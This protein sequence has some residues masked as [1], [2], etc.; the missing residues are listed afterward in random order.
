MYCVPTGTQIT[1]LNKT[2]RLAGYRAPK[3]F[4]TLK[5]TQ[6]FDV[7]SF[8]LL[9]LWW[10][11]WRGCSAPGVMGADG[12]AGGVD[13]GGVRRGADEARASRGGGGDDGGSPCLRGEGA[14]AVAVDGGGRED[15]GRCPRGH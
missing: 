5:A 7:Y 11:Q 14:G 10:R 6:T 1:I 4:D 15:V 8:S 12:G 2:S 9:L 3:L 13:G